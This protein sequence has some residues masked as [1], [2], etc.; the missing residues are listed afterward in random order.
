M[1]FRHNFL[2]W[3]QIHLHNLQDTSFLP[4]ESDL[5]SS[6]IPKLLY[7]VILKRKLTHTFKHGR[8]PRLQGRGNAHRT[9]LESKQQVDETMMQTTFATDFGCRGKLSDIGW[10]IAYQ[11]L[12]WVRQEFNYVTVD[13]LVDRLHSLNGRAPTSASSVVNIVRRNH[14]TLELHYASSS[15]S[16]FSPCLHDGHLLSRIYRCHRSAPPASRRESG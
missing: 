10:L 5:C 6:N 7:T 9:N 14:T 2:K 4:N 3:T 16:D 8:M 11:W 13:P 1:Q 12:L 15:S